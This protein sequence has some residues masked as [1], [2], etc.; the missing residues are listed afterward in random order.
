M[1]FI[2][3]YLISQGIPQE[4][5]ALLLILPIATVIIAFARQVVGIRGF[6]I[7]TPLI[8]AF[9]LTATGLKYGLIFFITIIT[10]GTL[11]RIF[12]KKFRLL[13]LPRM[14]IVIT[15]VAAAI[16]LIISLNDIYLNNNQL[17]TMPVLA[18]LV[19][20]PLVEKFIAVQVKKG[21][22]DAIIITLETLTLSVVCFLIISWGWLQSIV[23]NYPIW[24]FLGSILINFFLGKWS[25][26]RLTE[27]YRFRD[28]IKNMELPDKK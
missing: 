20:I 19:M 4:T 22:R 26:L 25:G 21:A 16:L 7:Y 5:V 1:S 14:A 18:V 15:I 11:I 28:V 3:Q 24:F 23:L 10:V 9:A 13:Y 8:I 27:Y 6:G 12:I 17:S 2:T